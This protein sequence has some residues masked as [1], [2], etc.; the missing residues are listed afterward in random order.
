MSVAVGIALAPM[1]LHAPA[2]PAG[3][4]DQ[5][6]SRPS[7]VH[8]ALRMAM[9]AYRRGD[10]ELAATLFQQ[11]QAGQEDLTPAER[12]DL[13]NLLPLNGTALK[14]RRDGANQLRQAEDALRLNRTQD[15]LSLLKSI[16]PNQQLLTP[17]AKPRLGQLSA[18]VTPP[19]GRRAS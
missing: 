12:R 16:A 10:Y 18:K 7:R 4:T 1:A 6:Q 5:A 2:P 17:A 9:D 3:T 14:A 19:P 8:D 15:A 11:A 13:A